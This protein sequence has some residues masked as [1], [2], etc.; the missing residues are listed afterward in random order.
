MTLFG[1]VLSRPKMQ[2]RR[3]SSVW[4]GLRQIYIITPLQFYNKYNRPNA[5]KMCF[6]I[7]TTTEVV[8]FGWQVER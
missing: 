7:Q 4:P 8:L 3:I 2:H 1:I 5:L 6:T